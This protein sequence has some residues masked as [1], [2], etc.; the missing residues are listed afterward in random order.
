MSPGLV[1]RHLVVP[2][3]AL[4]LQVVPGPALLLQVL[5]G[6]ALLLQVLPGPALLLQVLPGPALLRQ[7]CLDLRRLGP[8]LPGLG[9]LGLA[10][11]CRGLRPALL[12]LALPQAARGYPVLLRVGVRLLAVPELS[13]LP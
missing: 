4:L 9:C 7:G 6:P 8:V 12:G 1:V 10:F 3:P 5:P 11:R 2:G 13:V